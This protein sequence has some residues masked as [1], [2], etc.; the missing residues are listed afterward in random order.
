MTIKAV[1]QYAG[2]NYKELPTLFF[3]FSGTKVEVEE[4]KQALQRLSVGHHGTDLKFAA[5]SEE[6]DQLWLA[7][8]TALWAAPIL[9]PGTEVKITDV[10]VPI[11]KLA[12]CIKETKQDLKKSFLLAPLVGHVGDGNFHL[13]ILVDP[14]N[15]KDLAEAHKIDTRLVQRAIAMEGTCT[16]EH[17]VG[18]GKRDYLVPELGKEAVDLMRKLKRT[19]DPDN[20]M[21]PGKVIPD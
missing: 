1:N 17:G 4:Q 14:K 18:I 16:G 6:M 12:Q 7:R 11:S 9:K 13:F 19:I 8:K 10:C 2:L 3:E 20:I 15:P 21:N 5:N